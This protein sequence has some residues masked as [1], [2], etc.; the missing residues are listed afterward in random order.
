MSPSIVGLWYRGSGI[1]RFHTL[2]MQFPDSVGQHS[3]GVAF[4][5]YYL[6]CGIVEDTLL[7][8]YMA[9]ALVHDLPE[10]K[11]GD[12]PS[13]TKSV[14]GRQELGVMERTYVHENDPKGLLR[15]AF[16]DADEGAA[17]LTLADALDGTV[18]AAIEL[19]AENTDFKE[20]YR[21]YVRFSE[22]RI[23][24][25]QKMYPEAAQ[26]AQVVLHYAHTIAHGAAL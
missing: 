2:P 16:A 7:C 12:I 25:V 22:E 18:R 5:I 3:G 11:T 21:N 26:R 4:L 10:Y 8:R 13:P 23:G 1:R 17:A 6:L 20:A 9:A 14:L 15:R 24:V 19:R